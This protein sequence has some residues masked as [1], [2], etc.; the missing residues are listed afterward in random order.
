M[1]RLPVCKII[2]AIIPFHKLFRNGIRI[3][4]RENKATTIN[5]PLPRKRMNQ[6]AGWLNSFI[7]P[8]Y[9]TIRCYAYSKRRALGRTN[10]NRINWPNARLF[11]ETEKR[12]RNDGMEILAFD[13]P[14][15]PCCNN[16]K[17][18]FHSRNIYIYTSNVG[19]V[20]HYRINKL[21][22]VSVVCLMNLLT[23]YLIDP[24]AKFSLLE[25]GELFRDIKTKIYFLLS[26]PFLFSAKTL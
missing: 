20:Q 6:V 19:N 2:L 7:I 17:E 26:L 25:F 16:Y 24:Y 13:Q 11:S 18:I 10:F 3:E 4:I 8:R 1:N 22:F 12:K 23:K 5:L 14:I 21:S 9:F 15:I